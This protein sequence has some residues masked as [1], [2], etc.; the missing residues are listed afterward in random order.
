[1]SESEVGLRPARRGDETAV[2]ALVDSVYREYGDRICLTGADHDLVDLERNY[3]D[4]G[5]AFV[6]LEGKR[7]GGSEVVGTHAVLPVLVRPDRQRTCTFR[8]LYLQSEFRGRGLGS[9]LMAWALQQAREQGM[10]RVEFW[11]DTRFVT[12]HEI[13]RKWGFEKGTTREMSDG[14]MPYREYFFGKDL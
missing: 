3:F 1:M 11:S 10:I 13:F 12:A 2:I 6:V 14:S 5:G 8:R 7:E 4:R 9:R